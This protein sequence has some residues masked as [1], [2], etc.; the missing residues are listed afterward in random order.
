MGDSAA[1]LMNLDN[2]LAPSDVAVPARVTHWSLPKPKIYPKSHEPA[3]IGYEFKH[4]CVTRVIR[5]K[6]ANKRA[7][8]S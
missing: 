8:S 4:N 5:E 1:D 7:R 6:S 3:V 2:L